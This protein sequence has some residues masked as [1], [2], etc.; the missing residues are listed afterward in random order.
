MDGMS[1]PRRKRMRRQDRERLIL[2]EAVRFFA[3]VGFEGQ[4]RALAERLGV[5]Q[6]LLYR[7]FPD[8]DTLIARVFDE[9]LLRRWDS[10]WDGLLRD[11]S[12]PLSERLIS[13]Y[14]AYSE[15]AF[16]Y[17]WIRLELYAGLK[18]N[19]L[20]AKHE[21]HVRDHILLPMCGEMRA[22]AG[23]PDADAQPIRHDEVDLAWGLHGSI[24]QLALRRWVYDYDLRLDPQDSI[25]NLV[26]AFL[27]G[28]K[29][30]L[31]TQAA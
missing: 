19:I 9:M 20:T 4:T 16:G 10:Q 6:P 14:R 30:R 25:E 26:L 3:E 23:L 21:Q 29:Q 28:A 31:A 17:D 27:A 18:G 13:F 12:K 7:Y 2:Q 24:Y 11:R 8:K 1:E 15:T 5:T 22:E